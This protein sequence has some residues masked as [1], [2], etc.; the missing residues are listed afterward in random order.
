MSQ[1]KKPEI[2]FKYIFNYAYNPVYINGAHGGIS[3]RGELVMN[4]YLERPPLPEEVKHA[5]N[6]NGTIGDVTSEEPH[7]LSN[8][9]VRYIDNGVIL[10]YESA[11]NIHYWI[12]ERLKEMEAIEKAKAAMNFPDQGNELTH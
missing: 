1:G 4:F 12:G 5:I 10:N 8:S 11:R 3:P 6:P 9:M 2:A 7:D